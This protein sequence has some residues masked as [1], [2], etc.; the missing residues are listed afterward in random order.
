MKITH[1]KGCGVWPAWWMSGPDW[2]NNGEIDVIEG[3]NLW[4]NDQSTLHTGT[5]S[6]ECN[7]MNETVANQIAANITGEWVSDLYNCT[8]QPG[9]SQT[10][11]PNY[12]MTV[13]NFGIPF[14][15]N[16]GGV[17]AAELR[18]DFGIKM[19]FWSH[20]NYP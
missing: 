6:P 12:T 13:N 5:G 4:T 17:Y 8:Y 11:T 19:W 16:G 15:E 1:S 2:P 14:N 7:Y 20:E 10:P 3:I 9:C 18:D